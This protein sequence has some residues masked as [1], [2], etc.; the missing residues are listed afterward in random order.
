[1]HS[2]L[3]VLVAR[4]WNVVLFSF[5]GKPVLKKKKNKKRKKKQQQKQEQNKF[6]EQV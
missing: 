5:S 1:M 3:T 2:W 4:H 6:R